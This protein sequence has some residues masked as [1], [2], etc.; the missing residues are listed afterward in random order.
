M[1]IKNAMILN[2]NF[3]IQKADLIISDRIDDV[4]PLEDENDIISGGSGEILIPGLIDIHT[5][6]A[7]GM[8]SMSDDLDF[9]K[10]RR[11]M[12]ENGITTFFPTTVTEG[13]DR[14]ELSLERLADADGIYLEGPYINAEKKGAHDEKKIRTADSE[15][16]DKIADKLK[17]VALAPEFEQNMRIIPELISRGVKVS[18]GH[19]SADYETA[20]KAFDL[21]V[22]Q[23]V[24]TFN[25]MGPLGHREPGLIGAALDDE[26]VFCEV[27]SD[28]IHLHPAIVR[29]LA[30][31][32]GPRRMVLISDSMS[33]TGLDD[34][35][36]ILGGLKVKVTE[37]VAR[38]EYGSIAGSTKNLMQMLRSAISFGIP[39]NDAVEMASLT[40]A[41]SAGIEKDAG[42]IE[43]GKFANLVRLD[44]DLEIKG[45]IYRGKIIH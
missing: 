16:L 3:R 34:G 31:L 25:A 20:I 23:L 39:L 43:K 11:Y 22:S 13:S 40:P 28:G 38:T 14:I 36:Y 27:I 15:L 1:Y 5:H 45:V 42:S 44:E 8:D 30:K 6:G 29:I 7:L 9:D 33:A 4:I 26:R 10:W 2:E 35:D 41:R 37:G 17:F 32:L 19:S 18:A 12:L 21:G 24:H